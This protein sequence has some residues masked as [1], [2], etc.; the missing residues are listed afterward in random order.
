[1]VL[2]LAVAAV[3]GFALASC[4]NSKNNGDMGTDMGGGGGA[5]DMTVQKLNCLQIGYCVA[6]C[7]NPDPQSC[8]TMCTKNVKAGSDR[9]FA[10]AFNCGQ[11]YCAP[12]P[13]SG[14]AAA[15]VPTP[16]PTDP[17]NQNK[18]YLCDPAQSYAD[19]VAGKPSGCNTC[20]DNAVG[21]PLLGD[22]VNPPTGM[23]TDEAAASCRGGT[24]C[25]TAFQ[26]CTS[27]T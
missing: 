11:Q 2:A 6:T 12:N 23:C 19:C 17:T 21:S 22:G 10:N 3:G 5:L 18:V 4:G 8:F 14:M 20:L 7:T 25:T 13:D 15:C 9:K 26:A 1:M 24:M 27:D 16:D